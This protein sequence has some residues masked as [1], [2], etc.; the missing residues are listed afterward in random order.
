MLNYRS[1][2]KRIPL[3]AAVLP[4]PSLVFSSH[5]F[6]FAKHTFSLTLRTLLSFFLFMSWAHPHSLPLPSTFSVFVSIS[7]QI[8]LLYAQPLFSFFSPLNGSS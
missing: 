1:P 2:A 6:C 8:F 5:S 3:V 7:S 4:S